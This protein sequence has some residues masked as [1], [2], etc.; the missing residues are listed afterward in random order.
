MA[1]INLLPWRDKVREK[2]KIGFLFSLVVSALIAAGVVLL[3]NLLM[4][5]FVQEQAV[6]VEYIKKQTAI[7]E[8]QH[9]AIQKIK[10]EKVSIMKR[11]ETIKGLKSDKSDTIMA[12]EDLVQII[13]DGVFL[14]KFTR[15]NKNLEIYGTAESNNHVSKFMRSLERSSWYHEPSL[16]KVVLNPAYGLQAND[17][18]L[19]AVLSSEKD[20]D[21]NESSTLENGGE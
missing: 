16:I 2:K 19:T 4:S 9:A 18:E 20:L 21:Q 7:K 13:P 15:K 5:K 10:K 17:F 14:S 3:V 1:H 6:N 12:F 8:S 11:V